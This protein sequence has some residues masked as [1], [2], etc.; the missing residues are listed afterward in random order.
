M[1]KAILVIDM[2]DD[3]PVESV[4]KINYLSVLW[5]GLPTEI[6]ARKYKMVLKPMPEKELI[7]NGS[8]MSDDYRQGWNDCIDEILGEDE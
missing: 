4:Q 8:P 5:N 6:G 2:P 1:S 3:M 7:V